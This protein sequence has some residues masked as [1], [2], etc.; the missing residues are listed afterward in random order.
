MGRMQNGWEIAKASWRILQRDRELIWVPLI[1]GAASIVAFFVVASPGLLL[2][3]GSTDDTGSGNLA[4]WI[5]LFLASVVA[6]WI[7]TIGQATVVA[8]AAQ[9]MDGSDPTIGSS[10]AVAKS[11][12]GRLL[13]WA[14]LAT[15]VSV[16]LGFIEDRLGFLGRIISWIGSAAFAVISFL[17]LP[18]IVFEDVSAIDGFKR[19][20]ALLKSTWGEQITFS[21]G[22][23][24]IGFLAML[25]VLLV[26]G[27][28]IGSG[29]L[30]LQVV[31]VVGG[32]VGIVAV[33]AITTALS[34]VFKT[35]LYR[36]AVGLPVDD[37]Y[38]QTALGSAFRPR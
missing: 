14:L 6:F 11:R 33:I 4:S 8:G 37:A 30:A 26:A 7:T 38:G 5:F 1:A 34:A 19:S 18:V 27:L 15:V 29:L 25:P 35:A 13:E 12:M 24:L 16:V 28:L 21:F 9:R 22:M 17:A 31:G 36:Y 3:D 32:V 2:L 23:G 20:S 10:F